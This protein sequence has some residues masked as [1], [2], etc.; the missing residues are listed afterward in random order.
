MSP[1]YSA[2]HVL[3]DPSHGIKCPARGHLVKSRWSWLP[4]SIILLAV[5]ATL[6]SGLYL[7]V[8]LVRPQYGDRI[9]SQRGLAPATA[10]LLSAMIAKSIE[11]SYVTVCVAFVGQVLSRR[12]LLRRSRG[13]TIPEMN[14]R[15]W[16]MQPGSLL[17]QGEMLQQAAG[18]VLGVLA[19][20]AAIVSMLYTTAA[21][22]LV[23]PKLVLGHVE[24]R[25]LVGRVSVDFANPKIL[26]ERCASPIPLAMDPDFRNST[27]MEL[28]HTGQA[29]H[30]YR[31]WLDEWSIVRDPTDDLARRP[32]PMGSLWD[33]TS[34]T[35]QWIDL[36][37]ND[38]AELSER[39]QRLVLNVTAAMPHGG[40]FAAANDPV[41][42]IPEPQDGG[43]G[44]FVLDAAVAAPA[45]NVLCA[46]MTKE[47][48]AP[49]VWTEWPENSEDKFNV[50]TWVQNEAPGVPTY[51]DYLNR[52]VVD[53][54]FGWGPQYDQRPPVFGRLPLAYNTVLNT[55]G[56]MPANSVYLLGTTPQPATDDPPYVLCALKAKLSPRC[57]THYEAS[58]TGANLTV[59]C[60]SSTNPMQYDRVH[61]ED[62][63][64][65]WRLD[66]KNVASL[67]S[68][69]LSLGAGISDGA[70]SNARL[71]MQLVPTG[72]P[73]ALPAARPSVAEALAVLAGS[74]LLLSSMGT[75]FRTA[76]PY[77]DRGDSIVHNPV[78]ETCEAT[79]QTVGYASGG[80]QEWQ[81][82]FYLVLGAA[83]ITSVVYLGFFLGEARGE[84]ITDFTEPP[85]LFALALNSP[86]STRVQ[87]ACAEGPT[88]VAL[89]EHFDI[90]A[91]NDDGHL[92]IASKGDGYAHATGMDGDV[93]VGGGS[94]AMQEYQR[95]S[96]G[97]TLCSWFY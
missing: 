68:T 12:A 93:E 47:E 35:G 73:R 26:G 11:L 16:I 22:A 10:T 94:P 48:L 67:W 43:E 87:G 4:V 76:W 50:T 75:S 79:L 63:D 37:D 82:A 97:G 88:G 72:S 19:L 77:A 65:Q 32:P 83:F 31:E 46:G 34:L 59:N 7:V 41:N 55:T 23:S 2:R 89:E 49:L 53:D 1:P 91:A 24:S 18:T 92:F 58:A 30:N 27:C 80:S 57:L 40:I 52:T 29:Y 6:A 66:W 42:H 25:Q 17:V 14:L 64:G 84:Q 38:V 69:S 5:Y 36:K 81:R 33:N 21:E 90:A 20:T 70:A 9:G 54:I 3:L 61:P 28:K 86:P 74:T 96:R 13:I 8:A 60:E 95:L 45:V 51:P 56:L 15:T 71:L 39:H 85:N 44:N 62:A 78:A